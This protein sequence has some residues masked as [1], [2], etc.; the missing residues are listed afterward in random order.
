VTRCP[1]C[2]KEG[3]DQAQFCGACGNRLTGDGASTASERALSPEQR[4]QRLLEEAFALS[5]KGR[6]LAAIQTCQ[7]AVAINPRSTSAHSLL[8]TLYERQGDRDRAIRAYEQVLAL[9]PESTVE[10]RRLNELMGV[11]TTRGTV[12]VP[13]RTARLA[14]GGGIAIL[15]LAAFAIFLTT[16]SGP[17]SAF[18][19]AQPAAG[20]AAEAQAEQAFTPQSQVTTLPVPGQTGQTFAL[21]TLPALPAPPALAAAPAP[22]Q[23]VVVAQPAGPYVYPNAAVARTPGEV[24]VGDPPP[25]SGAVLYTGAPVVRGGPSPAGMMTVAAPEKA[26]DYYLQG[27]YRSAAQTY[28][29][30]LSQHPGAG[31]APREELGWVYLQ[32]GDREQAFQSY[33]EA[34]DSYQLDLTRGRNT[35]AARYGLRTCQ[36]AIKALQPR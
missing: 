5:E 9:S 22:V 18:P 30:Y 19:P 33:R 2:G 31:G 32:L 21:P 14:V 1:R 12:P 11:P 26:R 13:L 27:D 3:P 6:L 24:Q 8:G 20:P 35:E 25:M 7:Q 23:P 17:T 15:L 16:R 10:R 36:S 28:Q 34:R 4:A 29:V